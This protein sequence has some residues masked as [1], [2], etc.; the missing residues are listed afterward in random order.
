MCVCGLH[1]CI[2]NKALG[3]SQHDVVTS[4][5]HRQQRDSRGTAEGHQRG[6]RG[7]AEG[8]QRD[9]RGTAEG[10]FSN[11]YNTNPSKVLLK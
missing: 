10:N 9:S 5:Q 7:T 1:V 2:L 11:A 6:S 3:C 8:Q 4:I